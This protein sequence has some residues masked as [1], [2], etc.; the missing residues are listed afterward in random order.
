MEC[1]ADA[2]FRVCDGVLSEPQARSLPER[3]HSPLFERH[4]PMEGSLS[5]SCKRGASAAFWRKFQQM[6]WGG[7][8][9]EPPQRNARKRTPA[10]IVALSTSRTCL[11]LIYPSA[12]DGY[13]QWWGCCPNRR[14]GGFPR[15]PCNA[16][17]VCRRR[18]EWQLTSSARHA[19]FWH[20]ERHRGRRSLVWNA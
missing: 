16:S 3:S 9:R 1:R 20:A 8:D 11:W 14:S 6:L 4:W 7:I 17:A 5:T 10:R 18:W 19:A 12:V 2:L 15:W 13:S